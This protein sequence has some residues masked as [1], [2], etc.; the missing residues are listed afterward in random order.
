MADKLGCEGAD[1][2]AIPEHLLR[3]ARARGK[4]DGA[5]QAMML[6]ILR[7]RNAALQGGLNEKPVAETI[8]S[9]LVSVSSD[10]ISSN[11]VVSGPSSGDEQP[12]QRRALQVALRSGP[13]RLGLYPA[14]GVF[15]AYARANSDD[16]LRHE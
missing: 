16:E 15:T 1:G 9:S 8:A 2:L 14:R 12:P 10:S 6:D 3:L 13:R 11:E 4:L 7:A 5:V